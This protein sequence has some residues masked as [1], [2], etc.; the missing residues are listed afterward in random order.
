MHLDRI[1]IK[2]ISLKFPRTPWIGLES[3]FHF[4]FIFPRCMEKGSEL[5]DGDPGRKLKGRV[6]FGGDR[7][8]DENYESAIFNDLSSSPSTMEGAKG[9]D[10]HACL[11]GHVGELSD[12]PQAYT[13]TFN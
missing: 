4:G 2:P 7:V 1:F 11:P 12:A 5:P 9:V 10:V 3:I 8:T 6:V 13:Q